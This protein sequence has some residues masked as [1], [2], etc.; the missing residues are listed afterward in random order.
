MSIAHFQH[1]LRER[2]KG[3]G[4]K[5]KEE[6]KRAHGKPQIKEVIYLVRVRGESSN[7]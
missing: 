5:W 2:G 7:V 6:W 3:S 1:E 4:W